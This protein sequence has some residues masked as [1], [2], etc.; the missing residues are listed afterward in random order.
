MSVDHN[1]V[2]QLEKKKGHYSFEIRAI[3]FSS[4]V[5]G[6]LCGA[7]LIAVT[8]VCAYARNDNYLFL[9]LLVPFLRAITMHDTLIGNLYIGVSLDMPFA[10]SIFGAI[11]GLVNLPVFFH[12]LGSAIYFVAHSVLHL[13]S[14]QA[15]LISELTADH[16]YLAAFFALTI[17][18]QILYG[19]QLVV[20]FIFRGRKKVIVILLSILLSASIILFFLMKPGNLGIFSRMNAA[21]TLSNDL[22]NRSILHALLSTF[23][24]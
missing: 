16:G 1:L 17:C 24:N 14:V 22:T 2:D 21:V 4:A 13:E 19:I 11:A 10:M 20:F 5:Q 7:L 15:T 18:L 3:P 23:S 9:V 12:V 8:F 6:I